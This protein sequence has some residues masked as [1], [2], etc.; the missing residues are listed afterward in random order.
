MIVAGGR[1]VG[2]QE[3]F[4]LLQKLADYLGAT[5]G[6]TR[7]ASDSG[8]ISAEHQIGVTG[9]TVKPKLYIA[10]GISGQTHHMSGISGKPIV[11]AINKDP[12]A[13][14]MKMA[15]YAVAGDL[16]EVIPALLQAL[17]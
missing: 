11:V 9:K 16:Y 5:V 1:G 2:K 8:W 15:D 10:C 12:N 4:T 13:P 3:G 7:P 6:A 17:K 14:I